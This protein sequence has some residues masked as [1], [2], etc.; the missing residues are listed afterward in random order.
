MGVGVGVGVGGCLD[1]LGM[2]GLWALEWVTEISG[3]LAGRR[4]WVVRGE[5]V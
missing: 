3:W 4:L 1:W 2:K 5:K